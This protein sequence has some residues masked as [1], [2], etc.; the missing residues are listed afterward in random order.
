MEINDGE[1]FLTQEVLDKLIEG[2]FT[3]NIW[4][5]LEA[6]SFKSLD[7]DK[8]QDIPPCEAFLIELFGSSL[9]HVG[10]CG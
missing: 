3:V 8:N 5:L 10:R 1:G 2:T 9:F 6:V 7:Y 4:P